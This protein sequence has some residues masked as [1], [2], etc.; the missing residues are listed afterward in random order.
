VAPYYHDADVVV[1]PVRAGGGTRIKLLEAF[2]HGRPVVSTTIG[3]EGI[4]AQPD[5]DLLVAD[6]PDAFAAR[7]AELMRQPALRR[8]LAARALEL[9][10]TRHSPSRLLDAV[11]QDVSARALGARA[12]A[13]S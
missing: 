1:V 4:D 6:G 11:R 5:A 2:S 9:V 3:A 8:R 10:R 12:R 13:R 7:C